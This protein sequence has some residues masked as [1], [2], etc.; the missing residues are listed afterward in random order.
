MR[1]F[2]KASAYLVPPSSSSARSELGMVKR[3][4][5]FFQIIAPGRGDPGSRPQ[6]AP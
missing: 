5:I 4:E 1:I 6:T 3:D 2:A